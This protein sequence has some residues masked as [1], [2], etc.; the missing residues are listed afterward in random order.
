[1]EPNLKTVRIL[2]TEWNT[3]LDLGAAITCRVYFLIEMKAYKFKM[4]KTNKWMGLLIEGTVTIPVVD[5]LNDIRRR[6]IYSS[7]R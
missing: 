2:N 5:F 3:L 6:F 4:I 7:F 1:V